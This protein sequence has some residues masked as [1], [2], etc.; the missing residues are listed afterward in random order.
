MAV[1]QFQSWGGAYVNKSATGREYQGWVRFFRIFKAAVAEVGTQQ[2][3]TEIQ[4][5][6]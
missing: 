6:W 5:V 4:S 1:R 2:G 3:A